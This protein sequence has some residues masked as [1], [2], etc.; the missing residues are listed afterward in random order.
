[1]VKNNSVAVPVLSIIG[2]SMSGGQITALRLAHILGFLL[3]D[4]RE[5]HRFKR[6]A[7]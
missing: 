1:M 6:R 2:G 3:H 5:P 4:A 7:G